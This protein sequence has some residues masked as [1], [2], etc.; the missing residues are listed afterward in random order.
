VDEEEINNIQDARSLFGKISRYGRTS[1][2]LLNEKGE[3]EKLIF[4]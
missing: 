3:K 1:I 2:T 4:Q